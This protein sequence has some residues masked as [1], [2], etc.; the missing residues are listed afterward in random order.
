MVIVCARQGSSC[1]VVSATVLTLH[2]RVKLDHGLELV[3]VRIMVAAS[4]QTVPVIALSHKATREVLVL[5]ARWDIFSTRRR[6]LV[7]LI[8]NPLRLASRPRAQAVR[9]A[10]K[11][12]SATPPTI[13]KR[14]TLDTTSM[15]HFVVHL[16]A[17][18]RQ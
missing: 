16:C 14:A 12:L 17:L 9:C 11:C 18:R 13:A 2:N 4:P 3:S 15:V 10:R 6:T 1:L 5:N 7:N 8:L